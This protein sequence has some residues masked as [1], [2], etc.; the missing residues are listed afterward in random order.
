LKYF[1]L[2][3]LQ[4]HLVKILCKVIIMWVNYKRKKKGAFLMKHRVNQ[5]RHVTSDHFSFF[6][7]TQASVIYQG[8]L[9]LSLSPP[10]W[11]QW[12]LEEIKRLAVLSVVPCVCVCTMTRYHLHAAQERCFMIL[13]Y[14]NLILTL[15]LTLTSP[16]VIHNRQERWRPPVKTFT[17]YSSNV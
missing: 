5:S 10:R 2:V 4:L 13:R 9:G 8:V 15:T 11:T 7:C 14:I 17:F 12:T 3:C 1:E 6:Q 16:H